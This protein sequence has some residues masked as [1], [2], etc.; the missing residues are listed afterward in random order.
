MLYEATFLVNPNVTRDDLDYLLQ[1]IK[2]T[3]TRLD[4]KIIKDFSGKK[5]VLAYPIKKLK[6]AYLYT[7]AFDMEPAKINEVKY[8]LKETKAILRHLLITKRIAKPKPL[9]ARMPKAKPKK[10]KPKEK[11]KIEELDKKLEELL[12]E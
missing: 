10:I 6:Q 1:Q 3:I 2:D 12:E 8:Q 7:V 11:I 4:G 9:V 5:I